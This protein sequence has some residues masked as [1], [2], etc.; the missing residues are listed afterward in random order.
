MRLTLGAASP[1]DKAISA[2]WM[3][4]WYLCLMPSTHA[5]LQQREAHV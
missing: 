4:L 5:S 3:P 1:V 2:V